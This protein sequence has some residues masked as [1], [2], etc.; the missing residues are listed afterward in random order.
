MGIVI[1]VGVDG[2]DAGNRAVAYA[3]D[4]A[5]ALDG[6]VVLAH[7]IPWSPYSF[8]TPE[9]NEERPKRRAAELAAAEEQVMAPAAAVVGDDVPCIPV[10]KHGD[11]VDVL[12][13]LAREHGAS[14]I[15]VGRTGENRLR[16]AVFGSVPSHLVQLADVPVTVVP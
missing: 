5:K 14:Q 11:R 4:R 6:K 12:L 13:D 15:L 10:V 7:V 9:D 3:R 1:L 2:S 16:T 8:T